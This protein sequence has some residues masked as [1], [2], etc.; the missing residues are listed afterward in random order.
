MQQQIRGHYGYENSDLLDV[1]GLVRWHRL[2]LSASVTRV[3]ALKD[4]PEGVRQ[5]SS[6]EGD[7]I[8]LILQP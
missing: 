7:P 5:V 2:D 3:L 6:K 4:A 1:V 8:R